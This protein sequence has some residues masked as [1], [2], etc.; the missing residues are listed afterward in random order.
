MT[1]QGQILGAIFEPK[2]VQILCKNRYQ[3]RC[4]KSI[5]KRCQND[6][7]IMK[8]GPKIDAKSMHFL[9][10]LFVEKHVFSCVLQGFLKV[11]GPK[12]RS[13]INQKSV[14]NR[15]SKK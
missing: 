14:E 8:N 15:C 4:R 6:Q 9:E 10:R 3:N 7:Q 1:A 11:E 12:S 5:E 13:T 2:S